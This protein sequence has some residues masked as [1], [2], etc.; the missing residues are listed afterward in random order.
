MIVKLPDLTEIQLND[1][2]TVKDVALSISEGLA[3][4]AVAGEVDGVLVDL[5]TVLSDG[6]T[7]RII[8]LRDEEGLKVYRHNI[9][10]SALSILTKD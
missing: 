2:A 8:T 4:N 6:Q 1:G 7:V 9:S 3:R 10:S 5:S